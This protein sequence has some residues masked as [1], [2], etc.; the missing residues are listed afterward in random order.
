MAKAKTYT[1][2][3]MPTHQ[4][5]TTQMLLPT[6][7][8]ANKSRIELTTDVSGWGSANQRTRPAIPFAS[9]AQRAPGRSIGDHQHRR[10][11]P[12]PAQVAAHLQPVLEALPLAQHDVQQ[13]P[14]PSLVVVLGHQHALQSP[15][16]SRT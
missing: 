12:A 13:H 6:G 1:T 5:R 4:A 15:R 7:W 14:L 16:L 10:P 2:M 9:P 3:R 11:E 8:P